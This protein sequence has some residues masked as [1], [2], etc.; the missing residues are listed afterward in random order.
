MLLHFPISIFKPFQVLFSVLMLSIDVVLDVLKVNFF[1]HSFTFF[2][3]SKFVLMGL[4]IVLHVISHLCCFLFSV[5][6]I[7]VQ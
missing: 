2:L 5:H 7:S 1:L 3:V 4:C 6:S